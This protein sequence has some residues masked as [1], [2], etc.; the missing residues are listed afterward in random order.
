M[1]VIYQTV[2]CDPVPRKQVFEK[3]SVPP[4][5]SFR[6]IILSSS[7]VR[8]CVL[9]LGWIIHW[10]TNLVVASGRPEVVLTRIVDVKKH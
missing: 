10:L 1:L 7:F 3:C 6:I 4:C 2:T 8:V 5:K 9:Y